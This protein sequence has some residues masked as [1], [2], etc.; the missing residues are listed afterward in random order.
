MILEV[1]IG[2]SARVRNTLSSP[3]LCSF[4]LETLTQSDTRRTDFSNLLRS[5]APGHTENVRLVIDCLVQFKQSNGKLS[6]VVE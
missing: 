1:P 5:I 6:H 4:L 2:S 3:R